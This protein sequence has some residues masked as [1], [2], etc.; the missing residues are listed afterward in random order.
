M[1]NRQ[2]KAE[3]KTLFPNVNPFTTPKP[4]RLMERILHIASSPGEMVAMLKEG[5]DVRNV[6]VIASVRAMESL[7]L[8]EQ[9]LGRELRLPFGQRTGKPMLDTVEVLSHHSFAALLQQAK[10]LLEET[11]G[12]RTD[13]AA[14]VI[15]PTA[16]K[17]RPVSLLAAATASLSTPTRSPSRR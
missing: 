15:D 4:E 6:Y 9:V 10:V 12:D 2:S 17:Q 5:W 11:L 3:L 8:T 7:L 13:A 16:G 14:V 1:A